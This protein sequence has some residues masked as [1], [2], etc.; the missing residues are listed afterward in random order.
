[1]LQ[2]GSQLRLPRTLM[3]DLDKSHPFASDED[4]GED[5]ETVI[6]IN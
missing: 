6:D 2:Q 3:D 5:D 1:M 4:L